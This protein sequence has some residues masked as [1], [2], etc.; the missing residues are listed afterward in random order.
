VIL[1]DVE[2]VVKRF[3]PEAVLDGVTFEVRPG[4]RIGLVGPNGAGKT[5]LLK[6][7]AGV[8]EADNGRVQPHPSARLEYLE[9]Q[10][11]FAPGRTLWDEAHSALDRFT[12]LAREAEEV[13]AA[14]AGATNDAE[15]ARLSTR[16]DRL[17][18]EL[19]R[20]DAY[21]LDHRVERVL[22][23]AA[24][25]DR[26]RSDVA[27][28]AVEPPGHRRHRVAGNLPG[29]DAASADRGQPRPLLSG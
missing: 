28:R 25:V 7:L 23:G 18:H 27:G 19:H 14:I 8:M 15:R 24:A 12:G 5:T 9:Q 1:L 13:A 20:H 10:P 3:G 22:D 26:A 11:S 4:E 21:H 16:F 29:R 2:G 17:Q 6:I